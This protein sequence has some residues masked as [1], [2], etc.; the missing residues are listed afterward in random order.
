MSGKKQFSSNGI[1]ND[2]EGRC[3]RSGAACDD[4]SVQPKSQLHPSDTPS[5]SQAKAAFG[6][7]PASSQVRLGHRLVSRAEKKGGADK[8][9]PEE[10]TKS[11][12]TEKVQKAEKG[13][14]KGSQIVEKVVDLLWPRQAI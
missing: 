9:K 11:E 8:K 6:V 10:D 13:G 12:N 1:H 2:A 4:C 3:T 14:E 7:K 5:V